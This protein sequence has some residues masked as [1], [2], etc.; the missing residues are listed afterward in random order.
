LLVS[1]H[2][3]IE[4]PSQSHGIGH[5]I[6]HDIAG[7][8]HGIGIGHASDDRRSPMGSGIG[9]GSQSHGIGH[10]IA[11]HCHGIGIGHDSDGRCIPTKNSP[12]T[13]NLRPVKAEKTGSPLMVVSVFHVVAG[14]N[15]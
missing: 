15:P 12:P 8:C 5:G 14:I 9:T 11:G 13:E 1:I 4:R 10:D 7:H 6:G 2:L 3:A